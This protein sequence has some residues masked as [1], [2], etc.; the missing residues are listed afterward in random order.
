MPQ[1]DLALLVVGGT[2]LF[3]GAFSRL[4]KRWGLP[5]PLFALMLGFALGPVGAD[6]L[7]PHE[8][9]DWKTLLEQTMR[10]TLAIGL[11]GVALRIPDAYLRRQWRSVALVTGLAMLFAWAAASLLIHLLLGL[12]GWEAL[13]VGAIV[14]PTDPV[15]ASSIVTGPVATRDLP[16][17]LR[18]LISSES[19]FNDGLAQPFVLLPALVLMRPD[20]Q[21]LKQ[22]LTHVIPW[23]IGGAVVLGALI[24]HG[25]GRLLMWAEERKLIEEPSI[26]AY[27]TALTLFTLSGIQLLGCNGVLAVFVAGL[28]FGH[29]VGAQ[30]RMKE[31]RVVEGIDQL[32][33]LPSFIL[34]G[35]LAPVDEWLALGW[36]AVLLVCSV[37][38]LR[39]LPLFVLLGGRLQ[40]L[41]RLA[42]GL[43]AGWFG[44]I[45]IAAL[46]YA[47]LALH[48]TELHVVWVV[49]SLLVCASVAVH[50]LTATPFTRLYGRQ[51][52]ATRR[53]EAPGLISEKA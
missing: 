48:R 9:G 13:L 51:A 47:S 26:E 39:R 27:T 16:E 45:G 42:D 8:W 24:G 52:S 32:F 11:M 5:D 14:T 29:A 15:V 20:G 49:A 18:H 12:P 44:P 53:R 37:L 31:E 46:F 35:L 17:R 43:F 41:P 34:L 25:A 21:A 36:S 28:L 38:L 33:T 50:G 19:G 2:V 23:E 4:F 3:L 40:G 10:L 1:L 6:M 30:E 22:W 7:R